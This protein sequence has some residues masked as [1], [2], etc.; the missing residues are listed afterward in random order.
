MGR[1]VDDADLPDAVAHEDDRHAPVAHAVDEVQRAVDRIDQP[2]ALA[3]RAAGF[4]AEHR[5]ARERRREPFA[6]VR[7][8]RAIGDADPVLLVALRFGGVV[9]LAMEIA[10]RERPC[11]ARESRAESCARGELGPVHRA[12]AGGTSTTPCCASSTATPSPMAWGCSTAAD[13]AKSSPIPVSSVYSIS[14]PR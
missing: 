14:P 8:D 9:E 5:I 1:V 2:R 7:F 4:L 6:T 3:D 10:K 12:P 13:T 11:L